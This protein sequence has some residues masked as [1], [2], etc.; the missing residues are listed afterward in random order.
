MNSSKEL[1]PSEKMR[2]ALPDEPKTRRS[3]PIVIFL[4]GLLTTALLASCCVCGIAAW[5]FRPQVNEN[6]ERAR[7]LTAQIV[8]ISI[9]EAFQPKGTIEWNL[10]FLMR[11]RGAYYERLVG[12]GVLTLLE[13][14]TRLAN[15]DSVR[16]HVVDTLL[17]EGSSGTSLVIEKAKTRKETFEIAGEPVV[18]T[19]E[20]ARDPRTGSTFHLVEGVFNGNAGQ[21]LLAM[22]VDANHWQDEAVPLDAAATSDANAALPFWLTGMI[23]SIGQSPSGTVPAVPPGTPAD[24]PLM[25]AG[26]PALKPGPLN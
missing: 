4:T 18:F 24:S 2:S 11:L 20:L 5:W 26:E 12:D 22:R 25:P 6:P 13:V 17:E 8:S 1:T 23:R 15:D 21:V 9:P 14:N 7:E 10:G 19:I 16:R 3:H